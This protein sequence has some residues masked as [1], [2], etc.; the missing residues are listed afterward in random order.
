[1]TI[2]DAAVGTEVVGKVFHNLGA[3]RENVWSPRVARQ[4]DGTSS[5]KVS[6]DLKRQQALTS[7]VL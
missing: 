6:A 4:L 3:A 5:D 1:M 2:E 7:V